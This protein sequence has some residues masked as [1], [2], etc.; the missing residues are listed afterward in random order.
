MH[1][2]TSEFQSKLQNYFFE[3][4]FFLAVDFLLVDF[5]VDDFFEADFL[6]E[7]FDVVFFGAVFFLGAFGTLAPFS[8]ASESPIAIACFL[9]FT[10]LSERPIFNVPFFSRFT[11]L[12]TYLLA[13]LPYL[14]LLEVFF[15]A[16]IVLNLVFY[17]QL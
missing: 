2:S 8:L 10:D 15:F 3:V 16:G 6:V 14:R 7:V 13:A 9:L 12:S 4:D 11:A 5:L 1:S 17:S